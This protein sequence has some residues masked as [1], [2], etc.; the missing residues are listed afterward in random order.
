MGRGPLQCCP[1]TPVPRSSCPHLQHS[2][3]GDNQQDV[4][5]TISLLE[6]HQFIHGPWLSEL[7]RG[8]LPTY[9]ALAIHVSKLVELGSR[10]GQVAGCGK[11]NGPRTVV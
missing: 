5:A 3:L 6:S 2:C 4:R 11:N 9:P 1:P 8:A 10:F 7:E